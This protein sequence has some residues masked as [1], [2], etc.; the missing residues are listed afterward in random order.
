MG[1]EQAKRVRL[2]MLARW[3]AQGLVVECPDDQA[4]SLQPG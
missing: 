4:E 1:D 2:G 3:L